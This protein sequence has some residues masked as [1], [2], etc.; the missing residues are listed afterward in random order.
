[1]TPVSANPH[2]RPEQSLRGGCAEAHKRTWLDH[3]ELGLEPRQASLDLPAVRLL[4]DSPLTSQLV[5]EVLD[6]I[7]D[8]DLLARKLG[9]FETPVEHAARWA[10]KRVT[11]PVLSISGLLPDEH[12]AGAPGAFAD[13]GL[14]CALPQI[15]RAA[16]FD[17]L[18]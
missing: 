16:A 9:A 5:P 14:R 8:V 2:L 17:R 10:Y 12:Y 6:H 3:L 7:G 4:V 15:A 13:H 18:A 11:L 1:L